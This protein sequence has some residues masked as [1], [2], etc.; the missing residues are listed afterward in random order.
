MSAQPTFRDPSRFSEEDLEK[1]RRVAIDV[2]IEERRKEG[3]SRYRLAFNRA[4]PLVKKLF[5]ETKNLTSLD[6]RVLMSNPTLVRAGR[7]LAAP[8]VS[9]DDLNTLV[10]TNVA[11]RKRMDEVSARHM[12]GTIMSLVDPV[13]CP[14]LVEGRDPRAH[15]VMTAINWT[16]GLIAVERL[17]TERRVES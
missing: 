11:K 8:P 15:E 10:G 6:E 5:R 9:E 17:R 12:L 16:A 1:E 13:R 7:F 3:N 4:L 2:F 14:W